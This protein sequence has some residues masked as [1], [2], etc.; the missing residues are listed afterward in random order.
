MVD[1]RKERELM[2]QQAATLKQQI[3]EYSQEIGIDKIGFTTAYPFQ[4]LKARLYSADA[5]LSVRV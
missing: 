3:I 2:D 5:W 1:G 4:D